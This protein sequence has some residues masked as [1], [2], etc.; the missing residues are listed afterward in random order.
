MRRIYQKKVYLQGGSRIA[1]PEPF[2]GHQRQPGNPPP[3]HPVCRVR[4]RFWRPCLYLPGRF[5]WRGFEPQPK[6]AVFL[7]QAG[8][9]LPDRG[10]FPPVGFHQGHDGTLN[11]I[12]AGGNVRGRGG[13]GRCRL[14]SGLTEGF[15]DKRYPFI[16]QIGNPVFKGHR[17]NA[18]FSRNRLSDR[19]KQHSS[20]SCRSSEVALLAQRFLETSKVRL[21]RKPLAKRKPEGQ[22]RIFP[23]NPF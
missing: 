19:G 12:E 7:D 9:L 21:C 1:T 20:F 13:E 3:W 8:H 6:R 16:I 2:R 5:G 23:K 22:V 11:T 14:Y 4:G 18:Y 15:S 17:D 10:G